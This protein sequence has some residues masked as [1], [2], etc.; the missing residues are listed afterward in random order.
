MWVAL[1]TLKSSTVWMELLTLTCSTIAGYTLKLRLKCNL[2]KWTHPGKRE[3]IHS[4][5][6]AQ[7][8]LRNLA[9]LQSLN[10]LKAEA[11]RGTLLSVHRRWT[12]VTSKPHIPKYEV[13]MAAGVDMR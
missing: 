12:T 13:L 1:L 8:F 4:H 3:V 10:T 11:D 5:A 6:S 9:A 7:V 2:E